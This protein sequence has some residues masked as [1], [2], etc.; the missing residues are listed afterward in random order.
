V[1][2]P[3]GASACDTVMVH[4]RNVNQAPIVDL[5]PD[6]SID[7]GQTI[8][9][10]PSVTDP[11]C[12]VLR[13][14]WTA[15]AGTFDSTNAVNPLFTVPATFKCAGEPIVV[16]LTVTD[17]CGLT[18]T[19]SVT[20]QVRNINRAPTVTLE[21]GLCVSEGNTLTLLP[22]V[23]DPDGDVLRYVWTVSAGRLDSTCV[24]T[25]VFIAP[26]IQDC[27]GIDVTVTLTVTDPCGLTATDSA[28][29]R[30]QNVNAAPIVVADP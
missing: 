15:S 19:D 29:I 1:I 18:A 6:F 24:A 10:T 3:C 16:T 2:D 8:R 25:P 23:A 4:V 9:W 11:E 21:S 28:V 5:G 14:C 22:Q 13:Y 27:N 20:L 26:I 30:V 17:P 7:E 12:D